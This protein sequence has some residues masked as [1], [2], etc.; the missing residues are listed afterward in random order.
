MEDLKQIQ[1][2]FSKPLN[3]NVFVE[4]F[5]LQKA[6]KGMGYDVKVKAVDDFG[7][8]VFEIYFN[9]PADADDDSIFY[10][11]EKLGYDNVRVF[12]NPQ[13]SVKENS[14]FEK[15]LAK[16]AADEKEKRAKSPSYAA[17]SKLDV[18]IEDFF[19]KGQS[20]QEFKKRL[21]KLKENKK[22]TL[23]NFVQMVRDDMMAGAAPD[24]YP[25]DERVR[26]DAKYLY[27]RYLQGA[28]ID[29]LF[30][31]NSGIYFNPDK[32]SPRPKVKD[33]AKSGI[34]KVKDVLKKIMKEQES[35]PDAELKVGDYQTKYFY[36]CPG[37]KSLYQDIED[38]V[39]DMGLAIRAAKLQDA[40]FAIEASALESG[41]TEAEVFAAQSIADQI[42]AMAAMMGLDKE[43]SYIQG[44]VDKIKGAVG[45]EQVDE[46]AS[47]EEKRMVMQAIKR[48][49]KYRGVSEKE[50]KADL[51]RAVKELGSIEEAINEI[52]ET[53]QAGKV[54]EEKLC[55]KGEAYRK[56]RMA[57]G[58]KSSAYLS[59]RAVKVCKG[60][61]SGRKKRKKRKSKK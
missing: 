23:N 60:Q 53:I 47:T 22:L 55:K 57:A 6:L 24:E 48:F 14:R 19:E 7:K 3:E 37:A 12:A 44:H 56:R 16:M 2:F 28:S 5:K 36:I 31:Y 1:E 50:A 11:V 13:E 27:N 59:G 42:M 61:I 21:D 4:A 29:D 8:N 32:S 39:D 35:N 38:K 46:G 51:I 52:V 34:E 58:E 20:Y 26:K 41:A 43:H 9:N 45:K 54:L 10:D 40:L 15:R 17:A 33:A 49:A 30:E 18:D 25:S